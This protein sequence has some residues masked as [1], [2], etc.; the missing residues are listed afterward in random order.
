MN[1]QD[2]R[3]VAEAA[4]F[5][6][7]AARQDETVKMLVQAMVAHHGMPLHEIAA[8]NPD[9]VIEAAEEAAAL[10]ENDL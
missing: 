6:M 4:R 5:L 7:D 10:M 8:V 1:E 3:K 2:R 9:T